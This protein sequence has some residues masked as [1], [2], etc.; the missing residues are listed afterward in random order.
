MVLGELYLPLS[1]RGDEGNTGGHQ[2]KRGVRKL[3]E[4]EKA[5][6]ARARKKHRCP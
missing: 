2:K 4:Q 6:D 1:L 3:L 5:I